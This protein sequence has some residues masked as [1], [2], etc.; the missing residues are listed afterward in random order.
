MTEA[1]FFSWIRSYARRLS[2]KWKPRTD[3]LKSVRRPYKGD[4]KRVKWEYPCHECRQW[5]ILKNIEVD[6]IIPC[7]SL[8]SFDDIG[9]FY[10]NL[11]C[12]KDGYVTLCKPCHLKHTN[13]DRKRGR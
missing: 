10:K 8:Q 3:Y 2:I 12:E 9:V 6:H 7:G 5:L 13:E 1:Q 4:N 11:L